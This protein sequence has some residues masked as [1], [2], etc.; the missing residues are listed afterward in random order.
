[1]FYF[2]LCNDLI[3]YGEEMAGLFTKNSK[4]RYKF[5]REIFLSELRLVLIPGEAKSFIMIGPDK[6]LILR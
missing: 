5:H 4:Q 3:F 2:V 1:M 6:G